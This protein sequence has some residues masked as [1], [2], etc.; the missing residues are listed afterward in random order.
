MEREEEQKG[1]RFLK[2]EEFKLFPFL[3]HHC[4]FA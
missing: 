4:Q 3:I 1:Y 2:N